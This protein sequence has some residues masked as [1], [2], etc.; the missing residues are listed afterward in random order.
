MTEEIQV[1]RR[2]RHLPLTVSRPELLDRGS[3]RD[4]R[5]LVH[6]LFGFLARHEAI[7][8]GHA[9]YIGLNGMEYTVLISIAHL[10][11]DGDVSV[12]VVADH[13][14]LSGAFITTITGALLRKR[15]IHKR[16]DPRDRRRVRLTVSEKGYD[17]LA[18]LAPVQSR[19]ND[20][21]FE[22]LSA[23]EFQQLLSLLHRLIASG[24]RA[25]ALQARLEA[26]G[27]TGNG[28]RRLHVRQALA[29]VRS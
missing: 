1:G 8:S 23:A 11:A 26:K 27:P 16:P 24:D 18:Q 15:L 17:L 29:G 3:D 14:H 9:A 10:S 4:F 12:K 22:C 20:I 7:R 2:Y 13:L 21:E 19:I 28:A 5:R 25:L 6:G